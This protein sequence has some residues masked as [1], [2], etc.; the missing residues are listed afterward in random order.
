MLTSVTVVLF[1]DVFTGEYLLIGA[2]VEI[3]TGFAVEFKIELD[4]ELEI[5]LEYAPDVTVAVLLLTE[6]APDNSDL[7][8]P[9]VDVLDDNGSG[10][11][12]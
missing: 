11:V 6:L 4:I 5:E 8:A 12:F 10:A 9:K 2:P 7:L 3:E 1:R